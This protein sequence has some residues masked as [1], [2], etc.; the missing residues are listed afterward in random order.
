MKVLL[1]SPTLP[2]IGGVSIATERLA[3]RLV[4]DG[5]YV[6]IYSLS[7][8]RPCLNNRWLKMLKFLLFPFWALFQ[9]S[10]DIVHC[11]VAG[12]FRKRYV[13]FFK[14]TLHGAKLIFTL[15]GD[16]MILKGDSVGK[17]YKKADM[18]ICAQ[19]GDSVF[20]EQTFG[21]DAV[22]IPAFILPPP[23]DTDQIPSDVLAFVQCGD[24]PLILATGGVVLTSGYYDLYGLNDIIEI[25]LKLK[26]HIP[27]RLLLVVTGLNMNANQTDYLD[28][29]CEK[30]LED[31]DVMITRGLSMPLVPL[32]KYAKLFLRPTKTD[33]DALSVREALAMNCP[34]LASDVSV[35]PS[36]AIVYHNER[37]FYDYAKG[38]LTDLIEPAFQDGDFYTQIVAVY[39]KILS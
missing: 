32:F 19:C 5:H 3:A 15:H 26:E 11:H 22:D 27:V 30:V 20:I 17:A 1:F 39:E 25:Y 24:A 14:W 12:V 16:A 4:K 18:V 21:I 2:E 36:G 38:V 23:T 6:K 13:A 34:V 29:I 33:G 10:F 31:S 7:F 9:P 8:Q 35:R 28:K 37:E